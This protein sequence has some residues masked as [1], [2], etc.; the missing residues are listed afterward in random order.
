MI[1]FTEIT[2][3]GFVS[4]IAVTC[5]HSIVAKVSFPATVVFDHVVGLALSRELIL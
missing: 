2:I 4:D 3:A 5:F 1:Y